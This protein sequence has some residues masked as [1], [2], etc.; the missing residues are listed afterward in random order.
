MPELGRRGFGLLSIIGVLLLWELI[1]GLGLVNA[2][3]LPPPSQI[4]PALWKILLSGSFL[5][6]LQ[7]TLGMLLVGYTIACVTGV[8]LGLLMGC[9]GYAYGLLEPLVE[10]I[11]P[12]PKPALIPA[13]VV[14]LGIGAG[15]KITMVALAA[16]FPV[17]INTLQ[18]VR[19]VDPVLLATA[20]TLGCTRAQTIRKI[21][22]PAALPMILTGMRVSLGMGLVLVILAEMLAADSGIG[23]LILDLQ[24]SFQVRPMYAWIA[25]LAAVGLLLNVL[26]EIVEDRVVPWRAK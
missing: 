11:R 25:I 17:L 26:F 16:L 12:L 8:A 19:G 2:S 14:F 1:C 15:M 5:A 21:I 3:L 22:L 23:F 10:A 4:A 20:R 13:M 9:S 6:P 24:R 18:G 7:Q